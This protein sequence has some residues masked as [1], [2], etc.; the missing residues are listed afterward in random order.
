VTLGE[1]AYLCYGSS[2]NVKGQPGRDFVATANNQPLPE[3]VGP[4]LGIDWMEG[5]RQARIV[6]ALSARHDWDVA[7]TMALQTDRVCRPWRE[8][9][10]IVLAIPAET[11]PAR[12][13]LELL[14]SWDGVLGEDAAAG[15]VCA[16]AVNRVMVRMRE[17]KER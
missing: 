5:S 1:S 13:G 10:D 15:A 14:R 9:R 8:L 7:S 2:S 11:G 12:Q 4:F 16:V 17:P 6:E 3:G